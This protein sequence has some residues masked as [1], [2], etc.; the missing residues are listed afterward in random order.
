MKLAMKLS[1]NNMILPLDLVASGLDLDMDFG[2][3][4]VLNVNYNADP[5]D[6]EYEI[7]PRITEQTLPTAMK[8]MTEDLTVRAI[9]RYDVSNT[10]G[11]TTIFIANEV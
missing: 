1:E 8:L 6:G 2:D 4:I 9:P 5:Y 10:S 3:E 7:T 11:G